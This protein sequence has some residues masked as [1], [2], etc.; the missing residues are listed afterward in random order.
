MAFSLM[1]MVK[2]EDAKLGCSALED[3][4]LVA[5]QANLRHYVSSR[6]I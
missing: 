5:I 2:K 4:T 3:K 6:A 1:G